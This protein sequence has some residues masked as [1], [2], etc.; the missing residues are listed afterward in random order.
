MT[1]KVIMRHMVV[2]ALAHAGWL[3][4]VLGAIDLGLSAGLAAFITAF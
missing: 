1:R 4:P 2:D 3:A